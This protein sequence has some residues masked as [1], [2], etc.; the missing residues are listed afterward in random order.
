MI[1]RIG[2][3]CIVSLFCP[4]LYAQTIHQYPYDSSVTSYSDPSIWPTLSGQCHWRPSNSNTDTTTTPQLMSP[5]IGHTHVEVKAPIYAEVS[6]NFIV[7][8]TIMLFQTDGS[9]DPSELSSAYGNHLTNIVWDTP[10]NIPPVMQ[11]DPNGLKMWTGHLTVDFTDNPD[12]V[13]HGWFQ[14]FFGIHTSL[15]N[16][17]NTRTGIFIPFYSVLDPTSPETPLTSTSTMTRVD[18]VT[19]SA[20]DTFSGDFGDS[21]ASYNNYLP[22]LA[23]I[24]TLISAA[25]PQVYAYASSNQLPFGTGMTRFDMNLHVGIPGTLIQSSS[26]PST[27]TIALPS[28]FDPAVLGQGTHKV[29]AMWQQDTGVGSSGITA[30]EQNAALLVVTV[31]VGAPTP[32]PPP[33]M[34]MTI[35]SGSF[36]V[37]QNLM[38]TNQYRLCT[39]ATLMSCKTGTLQ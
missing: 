4:L 29:A 6:G 9:I 24:N 22:I 28:P 23:P 7:P 11:G 37:F 35:T 17:D 13:K 19:G 25:Q 8:F 1:K 30:N 21:I 14:V 26:G 2:L 34:W 27:G 3:A 32:P 16:G 5:Q 33:P 38:G 31:V 15:K 12:V 39:D 18:C 36:G 20:R 10:N